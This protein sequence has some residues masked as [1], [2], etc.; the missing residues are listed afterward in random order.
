MR[1]ILTLAAVTTIMSTM[2]FANIGFS[3]TLPTLTLSGNNY[4]TKM[5][6]F[7]QGDTLEKYQLQ[8][9]NNNSKAYQPGYIGN[10]LV[11][12]PSQ[13]AIP[14]HSSQAVTIFVKDPKQVTQDGE[15][16]STL[17]FQPVQTGFHPN[18][19]NTMGVTFMT[20]TT[21]YVYKGQ[22]NYT[23]TFTNFAI[24]Q[25][26]LTG[27]I[28]NTGNANLRL[29][30]SMSNGSTSNSNEVLV[31]RGSTYSVSAPIPSNLVGKA[32]NVTVTNETNN[33]VMYQTNIA[34]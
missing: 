9:V 18:T 12:F 6:L 2:A 20:G 17:V 8:L 15:Y 14:P 30:V 5:Y 25:G 23:G 32:L 31:Y 4:S 3:P 21:V 19:D 24:S 16:W 26:N 34:K 29:V 7:N 11:I 13:I 10:N 1:K 33:Q 27:S 28:Q 22:I